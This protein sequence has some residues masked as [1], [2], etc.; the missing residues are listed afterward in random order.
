MNER[1]ITF[2]EKIQLYNKLKSYLTRKLANN[3]WNEIR[4]AFLY[5]M[6]YHNIEEC[7]SLFIRDYNQ[8]LDLDGEKSSLRTISDLYSEPEPE[9]S[10]TIQA[11]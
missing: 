9:L 7:L 2:L 1:D 4:D 10:K 6:S 3:E 5:N 8:I 11:L